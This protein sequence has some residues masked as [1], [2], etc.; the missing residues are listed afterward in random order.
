MGRR[1]LA[2]GLRALRP[3]AKASPVINDD[4]QFPPEEGRW[5]GSQRST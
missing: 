1:S 4:M 3:K 5:V 2:T